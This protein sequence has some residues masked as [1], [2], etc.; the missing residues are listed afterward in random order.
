MYS[1]HPSCNVLKYSYI[2]DIHTAKQIRIEDFL[3]SLGYGLVRRQGIN[4]WYKSPLRE[5]TD[6]S[7]KVNTGL[8][9]WYDFGLGKGGNIIALAAELYA[10]DDVSY[11][12]RQIEKAAP[13]VRPF[14]VSVRK[15]PVAEPAFR[16]LRVLPLTS[17][18]LFAYLRERG[19]GTEIAAKECREVHYECNG[20]RYFAIGFPNVAGGFELRNRYFKGCI[21]PKD[22]TF[23]HR[24]EEANDTCCV[25]EGFMDYLSFLVLKKR[26][27][28]GFPYIG[29]Q[30]YMI[31]N[32][33][34]NLSKA[35]PSL[36]IYEHVYCY[37]DNDRAG[38][39]A[40][41]VL[42]RKYR[43]RVSDASSVYGGYKDL[44]EFLYRGMSAIIL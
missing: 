13:C 1:Y 5:E 10:S 40:L 42:E 31:L 33:V 18:A 39:D 8:N 19:I 34:S 26:K 35:L 22:I 25:F 4:L 3:H 20:K 17:P 11:L 21:A 16:Q 30:D 41:A 15:Q 27:F 23:V 7:F 9:C 36:G 6:A 29:R 32:S 37:F 24:Q 43:F 2:M 12:L 38:K 44:N 28:S 14:S